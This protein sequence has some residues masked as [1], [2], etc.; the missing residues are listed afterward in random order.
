MM[1]EAMM[2]EALWSELEHVYIHAS[3]VNSKVANRVFKVFSKEKI[4]VVD[5]EPLRSHKGTLSAE[6][7]E[8]SK[9]SVYVTPFL[10]QFFKRCPGSRPGLTCCNYFVL[11]LGQQCNMNCSYC[12]LQSFINSPIMKIYS[13]IDQALSEL[14]DMSRTMSQ[15]K[16]RIGTG[17]II[18]SLSLDPLTLYS[19]DLIRFFKNHPNWTLE[20]KTKS[21][22][23]DQFVDVE[24]AGN[25]IVS[26]SVNPQYVIEREEHGTASLYERLSA[27]KKASDRGYQIAFHIDPMIYHTAWQNSYRE[28]VSEIALHFKPKDISTFSIGG[29]RFQPEQRHMMRERFGMNSLVTSA[30]TFIGSDG[31]QRYDQQLRGEMFKFVLSELKSHGFENAFLCM[32]T[33]ETWLSAAGAMPKQNPHISALFDGAPLRAVNGHQGMRSQL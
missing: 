14:S 15:Q 9:K 8:R 21:S 11:N 16:L 32:E 31:K 1:S 26:F 2:A 30:E 28:L 6:Q 17:E 10:G 3:A 27:A 13:N 12:Y 25:V 24:H 18:D 33:P 29:L 20:F 5:D 22:Q 7:F 19:N 4:S 23:V